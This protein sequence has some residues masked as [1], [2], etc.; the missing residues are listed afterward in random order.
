IAQQKF[1]RTEGAGRQHED[2]CV[3]GAGEAFAID[4]AIEMDAPTLSVRFDLVDEMKRADLDVETV[5]GPVEIV[6]VE[7][8][9]C[10]DGAAYVAGAEV[11]AASQRGAMLVDMGLAGGF[12]FCSVLF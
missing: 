6:E 11:N 10:P 7:R 2:L 12:A 9:P 3:L 4:E 8:I 1:R 5:F